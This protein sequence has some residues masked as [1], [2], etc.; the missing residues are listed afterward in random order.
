M[1][2]AAFETLGC[3]LSFAES[4]SWAR[5][6]E[7]AG[8]EIVDA[9]QA[10][11]I[12][13]VN[14]CSVTEHAD[15]KGRNLIRR[16][17]RRAPQARIVVAGCQAQLKAEQLA[18]LDGVWAV[19]GSDYKGELL[20]IATAESIPQKV[21]VRPVEQSRKYFAAHSSSGRTRAFL[22]V[23]D[24][25]DYHCT[26]CTVPLARGDSRNAPIADIVAQAKAIAASGFK[27]VVLTGVNTGDF[28]KSTGESF[29]E[30]INALDAVDGIERYRI[31]SIEP[32]LLTEEIVDWIASGTKFLPHFHIPLQ[33]GCDRVLAA[34]HRRYNTDFFRRRIEYIRSRMEY[35]FF[36]IDV[37]VGF[38]GETDADFEQTCRFLE[39]IRPAFIH[40][41]PYSR[42]AGTP[43]AEMPGQVQESV[44][45]ER[46][47]RLEKLC[48]RLHDEF[49]RANRGRREQVLFESTVRDG[50]M[51]GYSRNYIKV[52]RDYDPALVGQIVDVIL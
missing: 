29:F 32:N 21:Y 50:K 48:G 51:F 16:L 14:T 5:A 39:E 3:K 47:A 25:C 11:D 22:K 8:F 27:E 42:R 6:F 1:R 38:P 45:T 18:A 37:I 28:G 9:G 34:M 7:A 46:V 31:S 12:Y 4:S 52:E 41:F 33:S 30:L 10:A 26:Y 24:G 19:V 15:K 13:V 23:Q 17:H 36:G 35:V 40:I 20:S 2:R 43:A 44:K 49:C